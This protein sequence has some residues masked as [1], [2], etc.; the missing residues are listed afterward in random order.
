MGQKK[1]I[2]RHKAMQP[3]SREHH[4]GLLLSWKI[5]TGISKGVAAERIK[6]YLNWFYTTHLVPH[7][8]AEEKLIFPILGNDHELVKKAIAQHRRLERLFNTST[9]LDRTISLIEEE[10]EAHIRFEERIL[11]NKI[12]TEA[13][14]QQ[15]E[16][17]A[18][19]HPESKFTE[20]SNDV[21]WE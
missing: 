6:T 10:L 1:P 5:R 19:L 7:F 21:F 15:L 13:N 14:E 18:K 8:E 3:L 11:F 4:Q 9:D 16:T 2:K 17:I 20:N 12:Q